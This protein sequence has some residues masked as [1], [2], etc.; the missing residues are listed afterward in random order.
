[1]SERHG[2]SPAPVARGSEV[3]SLLKWAMGSWLKPAGAEA[4]WQQ[5]AGPSAALGGS[6]QGGGNYSDQP[7][8][9]S[10]GAPAV[11]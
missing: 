8:G 4:K 10:E 11:R 5:E 9:P 1:M 7:V 3:I 6:G 2:I